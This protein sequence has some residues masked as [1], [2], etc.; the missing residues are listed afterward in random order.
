MGPV[1]SYNNLLS[2]VFE[3]EAVTEDLDL[4]HS[5]Q[6]QFSRKHQ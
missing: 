3:Q 4:K 1:T 5:L 6:A 2:R